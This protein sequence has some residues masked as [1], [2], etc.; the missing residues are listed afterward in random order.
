MSKKNVSFAQFQRMLLKAVE[1]ATSMAQSELREELPGK[2][3][4]RLAGDKDSQEEE[5]IEYILKKLYV[6][7]AFPRVVDVAVCGVKG[8]STVVW[9]RPSAHSLTKDLDRTWNQPKGAGPFKPMGVLLPAFIWE[10]SVPFRLKD[11][12]DAYDVL[13]RQANDGS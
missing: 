3:V 4:Y 12:V 13:E 9:V 1:T 10:R 8:A 5:G 2:V 7:G 6:D 11:L